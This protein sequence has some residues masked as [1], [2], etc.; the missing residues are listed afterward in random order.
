MKENQ[1]LKD[2]MKEVEVQFEKRQVL[3]NMQIDKKSLETKL[4]ESKY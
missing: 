4:M 1:I 2:K 3:Y